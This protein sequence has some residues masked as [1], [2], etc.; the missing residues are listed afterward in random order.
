M[1]ALLDVAELN[2]PAGGVVTA[3]GTRDARPGAGHTGPRSGRPSSPFGP[4]RVRNT[5]ASSLLNEANRTLLEAEWEP[6]PVQKFV[7]GYLAA[8]R[9][10][11]AM[12]AL[13]GRPHRGRAKPASAWALL[14][15]VAPELAEWS[16]FFAAASPLNAALRAGIRK[17]VS[18]RYADDVVRQTGQFLALVEQASP[19]PA[20]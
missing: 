2:L 5:G 4:T 3:C 12:L 17:P 1:S 8:L 11:A 13:R 10:A 14:S 18:Q 15:K 16:A 9:G 20:K 6:E 7:T 19:R